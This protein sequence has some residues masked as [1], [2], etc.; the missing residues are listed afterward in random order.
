MAKLMRCKYCGTL[1]DEPQ[2]AKLCVQCGGELAYVEDSAGGEAVDG[3]YVRAQMEL[4]Q[5]AAPGGQIVGRHLVITVQ[6][7]QTVPPAEQA[8][9]GAGREAMHFVAVLDTSGSMR[10][11]KLKAAKEAV[12][13][14]IRRLQ[15]ASGG[16]DATRGVD[17]FSLVTFATR[18]QCLL[19]AKP[20]DAH[21][22][23]VAESALDEI[24]A[25]G[26]TALC[27]G[28]EVGIEQVLKDAQGTNLVLLLS[29]GQANI[30]E[31]NVEAVGRRALDARAKGITVSTLGVGRDYN[32]ALMAEI[33][34]DGGGRFYHVANATQIAAYLTGE[35]GEMASLAARDVVATLHLPPGTGVQTLSAAYPV[36]EHAISLGDIP[37]ATELEVVVQVLLPPQPAGSRLPIDGVLEYRS[38]A[39][40]ALRTPLNRVT[41]RYEQ[42]ADLVQAEGAVRPI[43][44]R[45]LGHMQAASVLATSKAA[46]RSPG[47][48]RRRSEVELS[49]MRQYAALLGQD[50]GAAATLSESEEVLRAFSAPS[51]AASPKAKEATHAAMR[52]HRG[53]KDFDQA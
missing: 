51:P 7:P 47:D 37:L 50:E 16:R 27:G 13:Q 8:G 26:Q 18:A 46:A 36:R 48:A 10:G 42:E 30:G 44:R 49:T 28:L 9:G 15:G 21:L 32:E 20:V 33:A 40:N 22:R 41:V 53:S 1:Q 3:S 14:A 25:G 29:D 35:L 31:T 5:I 2:G 11:P 52:R 24:D 45:V 38:P 4:D 43:V 17:L 19:P 6:T 39:G 12:R 34:I 23:R